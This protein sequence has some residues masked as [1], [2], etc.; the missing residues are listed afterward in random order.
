MEK[1]IWANSGDSHFLEPEDLFQQILPPALA[2]RCRAPSK[3]DDGVGD[4]PHRRRGLPP[5]AAQADQGREFAGETINDAAVRPPGAGD[6]GAADQGPRPGGHLGRGRRSRRSG[7]W[8]NCI[9]DPALAAGGAQGAQRLGA[10]GDPAE[11]PAPAGR[12]PRRCRC[13]TSTTRSRRCSGR[14]AS[15][16]TPCTSR[17]FR[18]RADRLER[19]RVGAVLAGGRG[20][21]AWSSPSTSAPTV[22]WQDRRRSAAPAARC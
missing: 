13:W 1:K 7:M 2:E 12:A 9:K 5:P 20:D 8:A 19:R 10:V 16:F 4:R 3:D 17:P 6:I 22:D 14:R 21:R 11:V 18:R 15:G